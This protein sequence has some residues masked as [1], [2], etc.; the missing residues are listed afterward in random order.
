MKLSIA[1]INFLYNSCFSFNLGEITSILLNE[2]LLTILLGGGGNLTLILGNPI[3][4]LV[5]AFFLKKLHFLHIILLT[6]IVWH[7]IHLQAFVEDD[8]DNVDNKSSSVLL[9]RLTCFLPYFI[10]IFDDFCP[11]PSDDTFTNSYFND[12]EREFSNT[13]LFSNLQ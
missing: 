9:V 6:F 8:D 12:G 5:L 3:I 7:T 13:N 10:F 2:F 4:L 11:V 1:K